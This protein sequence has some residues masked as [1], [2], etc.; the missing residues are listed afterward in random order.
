M[1]TL[2]GYDGA[3]AGATAAGHAAATDPANGTPTVAWCED[4]NDISDGPPG[5]SLYVR[6]WT[7]SDWEALGGPLAESDRPMTVEMYVSGSGEPV[8]AWGM[9]ALESVAIELYV[10]RW[11]P[12]AAAWEPLGTALNLEPEKR[13]DH[14]SIA[15][16]VDGE[17]IVAWVEG[18]DDGGAF[19]IAS[20]DGTSWSH[21]HQWPDYERLYE[22]SLAVDRS[23]GE[24]WGAVNYA[25]TEAWV[26]RGQAGSE[27]GAWHGE[28]VSPVPDPPYGRLT[29]FAVGADGEV[30]VG[31]GGPLVS[32]LDR[33][34]LEW[35]ELP[36]L[37][38]VTATLP[39]RNVDV[40]VMDGQPLVLYDVAVARWSGTEWIELCQP[41]PHFWNTEHFSL[42]LDAARRPIVALS[43][44]V[45]P[46][47][48]QEVAVLSL[49]Q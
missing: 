42:A 41:R 49:A 45:T 22:T 3:T 13:V 17:P 29:D 1:R 6:R 4:R 14:F 11:N 28:S 35:R 20:W 21:F 10:S 25:D 23:T 34:A 40:A 46:G 2:V 33:D 19:N 38:S 39:Q 48:N 27:L 16:G 44:E 8:V 37:L 43:H 15:E 26:F 32:V 9:W 12:T 24:L 5:A 36:A 30:V 18:L 31:L 47:G 7:G